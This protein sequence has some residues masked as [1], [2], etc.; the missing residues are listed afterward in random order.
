[1][2]YDEIWWNQIKLYTVLSMIKPWLN[3]IQL[4]DFDLWVCLH[5]RY[6]QHSTNHWRA[7][8]PLAKCYQ[9]DNAK[10]FHEEHNAASNSGSFQMFPV[11]DSFL[12]QG[13]RTNRSLH[14]R[15]CMSLYISVFSAPVH[16]SWHSSASLCCC[17]LLLLFLLIRFMSASLLSSFSYSPYLSIFTNTFEDM[18]FF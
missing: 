17:L 12:M 4:Q 14:D 6:N 9:E 7:N 2:K 1:M 11:Q 10:T 16:P 8:V 3:Y 13:N 18:C 15:R 5:F